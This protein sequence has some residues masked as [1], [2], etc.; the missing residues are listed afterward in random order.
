VGGRR[1]WWR[2]AGAAAAV[3]LDAL[4]QACALAPGSDVAKA[5]AALLERGWMAAAAAGVALRWTVSGGAVST[6]NGSATADVGVS[7]RA[8]TFTHLGSPAHL[9]W[10]TAGT[11]PLGASGSV[12]WTI[13][14]KS[15]GLYL[16]LA[17]AEKDVSQGGQRIVVAVDTWMCHCDNGTL[18]ARGKEVHTTWSPKGGRVVRVEWD[19]EGVSFFVNGEPRGKK[20][21]WGDAALQLLPNP[22]AA[23]FAAAGRS[24]RAVACMGQAGSSATIISHTEAASIL[25]QMNIY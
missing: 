5:A 11:A 6:A 24:V 20:I 1:W 25:R 10:I 14:G 19:L 22:A 12:S 7:D 13:E 16:G 21:A 8:R 18:Y 23:G 4:E 2:T 3:A 9:E 15:I 17:L